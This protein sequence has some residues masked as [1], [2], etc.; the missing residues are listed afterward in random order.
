MGYARR[1][2]LVP[3]PEAPDW[4]T[5]N[6]HLRHQCEQERSRV[7]PRR[8]GAAIGTLWDQERATFLPLPPQAFTPAT[9]WPVRVSSQALVRHQQV[10]YSV[11]TRYVGQRVRLAAFW[12]HVEVWTLTTQ[13]ASHPLGQP[14]TPQL[15]LLHYLEALQ[16]KPGAVR[17]AR[18]VRELGTVVRAYQDAF[19]AVHPTAY[20][21]FVDILWLFRRFPAAQIIGALP[22]AQAA[23]CFEAEALSRR[24]S[25]AVPADRMLPEPAR[26]PAGPPV[27]Q[28]HPRLYNQLTEEA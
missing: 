2:F 27:F 21:A 20:G 18:V 28:P 15:D 26:V 8:G 7:L 16:Q 10:A 6:A 4:E 5:L 3:V 13:I 24:L 23:G 17:N 25:L 9:W 22:D 19:F 12:D 11:P 1:T 14:G